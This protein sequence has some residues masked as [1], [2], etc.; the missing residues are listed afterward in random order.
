[1]IVMTTRDDHRIAWL[2]ALAIVIHVAEAA[3][4]S[5]MPGVKPGLANVITVAVFIEFGW[6]TAAWVSLLRV[7][8]GS[9]VIGSFLTPGFALS[10]TGAAVS[11]AV[12]GLIRLWP[13]PSLSPLGVCMLSSLSH[14]AGQFSAAYLLFIPHPGMLTLL[15]VLMTLAAVFGLVSGVITSLLLASLHGRVANSE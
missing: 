13:G 6:R 14:M 7:L 12:L 8:V 10:L 3:I 5:P 2:A 1:M 9:L 15:P 4:P 11:V